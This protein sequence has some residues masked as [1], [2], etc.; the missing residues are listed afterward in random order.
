MNVFL[1]PAPC[2]LIAPAEFVDCIEFLHEHANLHRRSAMS[3]EARIKLAMSRATLVLHLL[4]ARPVWQRIPV[5]ERHRVGHRRSDDPRSGRRVVENA[6]LSHISVLANIVAS[7]SGSRPSRMPEALSESHGGRK[8][9]RL[10]FAARRTATAQSTEVTLR[11]ASI[12]RLA[13]WPLRSGR[14]SWTRQRHRTR[15]SALFRLFGLA[16]GTRDACLRQRAGTR[17]CVC[18]LPHEG[19]AFRGTARTPV[20]EV[21]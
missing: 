14:G 17:A 20:R 2:A 19:S 13:T 18:E 5:L 6:Q 21:G 12:R 3:P 11:C 8:A 1:H 7:T 4:R 16:T 10:T 9:D 15:R